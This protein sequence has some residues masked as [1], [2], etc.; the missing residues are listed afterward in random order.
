MKYL[1]GASVQGIQSFIFETNKLQ[2]IAGASEL[3]DYICTS[4]FRETTG[5]SFYKDE[6]LLIGAAGN[7][8]TSFENKERCQEL[9]A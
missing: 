9:G 3:V 6:S 4:L 7:I 1:Y 2:E 5:A 8:K